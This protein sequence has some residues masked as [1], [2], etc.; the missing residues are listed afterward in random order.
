[1]N[2]FGRLTLNNFN[3]QNSV[4]PKRLDIGA[5]NP[6]KQ[7]KTKK[8]ERKKNKKKG[9]NTNPEEFGIFDNNLIEEVDE[10][11]LKYEL[12]LDLVE[13]QLTKLDNEIKS[14]MDSGDKEG[15]LFAEKLKEKKERKEE[16]IQRYRQEY[17]NLGFPNMLAD[18]I[19]SIYKTIKK[20]FK[21]DNKITAKQL[22]ANIPFLAKTTEFRNNIENNIDKMTEANK[23]PQPHS[24]NPFAHFKTQ[25]N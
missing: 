21:T 25:I 4:A 3:N 8:V 23:T 7:E 1:M 6:V 19:D 5:K 9:K 22:E 12:K 18:T 16:D 11:S 15:E 10:K 20:I 24:T 17:R 2:G 13:N 14:A